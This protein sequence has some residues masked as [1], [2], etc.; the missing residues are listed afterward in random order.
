M[1]ATDDEILEQPVASEAQNVSADK[2]NALAALFARPDQSGGAGTAPW[3][4]RGGRHS[5]EKRIGMPPNGT[6]RSMGK[7]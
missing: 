2:R 5:H 6:R 1:S 3:Q 7:R 4:P